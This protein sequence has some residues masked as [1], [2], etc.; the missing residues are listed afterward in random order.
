[1]AHNPSHQIGDLVERVEHGS[2]RAVVVHQR[3]DRPAKKLWLS[4]TSK[5]KTGWTRSAET[6]DTRATPPSVR[7]ASP[8]FRSRAITQP[9]P[10]FQKR[11]IPVATIGSPPRSI[12]KVGAGLLWKTASTGAKLKAPVFAS[13]VSTTSP[14]R[15]DSIGRVPSRVRTGVPCPKQL[16]PV[17][18][19]YPGS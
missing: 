15:I 17:I 4:P 16:M 10:A 5:L 19:R 3:P 8:G 9:R 11:W 18:G 13:C 7:T 12:R 6:A 14:T 1:M 2:H